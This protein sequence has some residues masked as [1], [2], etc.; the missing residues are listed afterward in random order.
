MAEC[1]LMSRSSDQRPACAVAQD[2]P[3]LDVVARR[4]RPQFGQAEG[5][6]EA[7]DRVTNQQGFL[8]PEPGEERRDGTIA[9]HARR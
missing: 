2:E 7:W 9:E 5:T 1:S 6:G 8:V 4:Q 3:R